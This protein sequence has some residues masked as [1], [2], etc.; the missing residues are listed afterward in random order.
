MTDD[1]N[2][3]EKIKYRSL[4]HDEKKIR[5][6]RYI[7]IISLVVLIAFLVLGTILSIPIAKELRTEQGLASLSEKLSRYRGI[8]GVLVFTLIQTL[9]VIIAIVPPV[10]I[11][12]GMLFGWFWG[13]LLSY[14]GVYLGNFIVFM[15]VKKLGAPLVEAFVNEKQMNKFKFLQDEKKLTGILIILYLIPGVPKDVITYIVPLTKVTKKD[16]FLYVMPFRLPAVMMSTILGSNV[17]KGNYTTAIVIMCV[18][19][20]IGVAGYFLKDPIVEKLKTKKAEHHNQ[21]NS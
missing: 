21:K 11:V 4:S 1:K 19:V 15:L 17:G 20:A 8:S 2:R 13:G 3:P 6:K 18:F 7:Q 5:R 12:G 9:Q 10:Q 14:A 16:F